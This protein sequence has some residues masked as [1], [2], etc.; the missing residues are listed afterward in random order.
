M[1]EVDFSNTLWLFASP[2][3]GKKIE[4]GG[5]VDDLAFAWVLLW[6]HTVDPASTKIGFLSRA[7]KGLFEIPTNELVD[8]LAKRKEV[9][10]PDDNRLIEGYRVVYRMDDIGIFVKL[11][12][13][14]D[15]PNTVRQDLTS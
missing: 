13:P 12:E 1:N 11:V 9:F 3:C 8:I 10:F 14:N 2:W 7:C 5:Y 15:Q 6:N 4:H